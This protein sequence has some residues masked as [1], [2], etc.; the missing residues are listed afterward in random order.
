[1]GGR[2]NFSTH[3]CQNK[4][5]NLILGAQHNTF[6]AIVQ[7]KTFKTKLKLFQNSSTMPGV[8]EFDTSK[9]NETCRLA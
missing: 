4:S 7:K 3:L 6:S 5:F 1:M 8:I 2:G 9:S